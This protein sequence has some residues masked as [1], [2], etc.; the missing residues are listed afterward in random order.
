MLQVNGIV[1]GIG[2]KSTNQ[3][4]IYPDFD[5][6]FRRT[7]FATDCL[8]LSGLELHSGILS[9]GYALYKGY[10]CKLQSNTAWTGTNVYLSLKYNADGQV[11]GCI[12]SNAV[13]SVQETVADYIETTTFTNLN[14]AA[15]TKD[16]A[17]T[18]TLVPQKEID[19][20]VKPVLTIDEHTDCN[21]VRGTAA[22]IAGANS[23]Q[24][25]IALVGVRYNAKSAHANYTVT[26]NVFPEA[27]TLISAGE[28]TADYYTYQYPRKA[29]LSDETSRLLADG[30]ISTTATAT[31]QPID[32]SS[33][34]VATTEF[35]QKQM[36]H[37]LNTTKYVATA[38]IVA[39]VNVNQTDT[40][41]AKITLY[42]RA[43]FVYATVTETLLT[44]AD[45]VE[46][47]CTFTI[48]DGFLPKENTA[49]YLIFRTY[50]NNVIYGKLNKEDNVYR[51]TLSTTGVCTGSIVSK[52][53]TGNQAAT[54][55]APYNVFGYE[56]QA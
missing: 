33:L 35:V 45:I 43:R 7:A 2:N 19:S 34:K 48:P 41:V 44:D 55:I 47:P 15:N 22:K 8:V 53:A 3:N 9:A 24:I 20:N 27:V 51:M 42:K 36:E 52:M 6:T 38:N 28:Q 12:F 40:P 21:Q 54:D 46:R 5:A 37:D 39:T 56:C 13:E 4:V 31:T 16:A 50:T 29:K 10:L 18:K 1:A 14:E 49:V 32:D 25:T 30:I 17:L 11:N 23:I 26:Y